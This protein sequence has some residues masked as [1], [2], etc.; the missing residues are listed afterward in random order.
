MT[1]TTGRVKW[2]ND[3]KGFGFITRD[4]DGTDIFAHFK[5][6][7]SDGFK[8]LMEGR[9]VEFEVVQGSKGLKAVA[10]RYI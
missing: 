9:E 5:D 1:T 2:Y 7:Q 8:S 3:E 4:D 10:I 6:I